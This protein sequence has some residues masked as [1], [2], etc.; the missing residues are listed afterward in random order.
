[1]IRNL[2]GFKFRVWD[3]ASK[4]MRDLDKKDLNAIYDDTGE[5]EL[6]QWTGLKDVNGK[7]I[8][9]GDVVLLIYADKDGAS[10]SG[11]VF[12]DINIC[13]FRIKVGEKA[14]PI[15]TLRIISDPE[16]LLPQ[17]SELVLVARQVIGNIFEQNEPS[18]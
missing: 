18:K 3:R 13:A 9:E 10:L 12:Y 2:K 14:F 16:N 7:N 4:L 1:M 11:V 5:L 8:Y 17:K 6:M 15:V